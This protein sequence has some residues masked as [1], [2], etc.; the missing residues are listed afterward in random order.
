MR[1]DEKRDTGEKQDV[2][3]ARNEV[4]EEG[5]A[6]GTGLVLL[7]GSYDP[8]TLGHR[9][10]VR[11]ALEHCDEA[12]VAVM[13]NPQK[14]TLFD[15][16]TRVEI[17]GRTVADM[18]HVRVLSDTGMLIDLFDRLHADA[19]CKG[20]RNEEDYAYEMK[21]AEWNRTHNPRFRT[22]L[23]H[24]QGAYAD[25]SSTLVRERLMQGLPLTGLVHPNA[26]PL[27]LARAGEGGQA[28][29]PGQK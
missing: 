7:P 16:D 29:L 27:I 25:V 26:L 3:P 20:W 6:V 9:E 1:E 21:M 23:L 10:L 18:P 5:G 22:I 13:V 8:M 4:Y 24:S 19:V 17:A 15:L 14:H 12:V 2:I 11:R 28:S